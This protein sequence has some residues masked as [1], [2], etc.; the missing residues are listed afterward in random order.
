MSRTNRVERAKRV[1]RWKDRGLTA[2]EVRR[3]DGAECLDA[4]GGLQARREIEHGRG[5]R[6]A[7]D[8][9]RGSWA[10][11]AVRRTGCRAP[12]AFRKGRG[13]SLGGRATRRAW[14]RNLKRDETSLAVT[15]DAA[16]EVAA[17]R[18]AVLAVAGRRRSL[19]VVAGIRKG[20]RPPASDVW[21][22]FPSCSTQRWI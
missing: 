20:C 4:V 11:A 17:A 13:P 5:R 1:E 2:K 22:W 16:S 8:G 10:P 12:W 14:S 15:A 19:E 9:V 3:G 6:V 7:V 18:G 21:P